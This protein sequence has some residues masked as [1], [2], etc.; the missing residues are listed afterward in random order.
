MTKCPVCSTQTSNKI[1]NT[2]YWDCGYCGCW[3]Q[4]PLPSKTYEADH[5]KGPN[6]EFTGHLMPDN[7]KEC[8]RGLATFIFTVP[9]G[10]KS[11]PGKMLDIGAKYPYLSYCFKEL[12]CEAYAMDNIEIVPEYSKELDVPMLM[13][14]F[15]KI[16]EEQIKEW[17]KTEKFDLITMI[18]TFEHMEHPLEALKKMRKLLSDDGSLFLRLPQHDVSGYERDLTTGHYTIHPFF[19]SLSSLLELLVQARN[20]FTVIWQSP[21]EGAGQRDLILKPL[22]KK[23][24]IW[25]G[26]I[27]KNEERDLPLCLKTIEAVVDGIVIMDTGSTDNTE[28]NAKA[29]WHKPM[30]YETY[31]GASKQDDKGDWKLWDFGKARNQ[32]VER[33]EAMPE[34]DYLIWFDAD[35]TLLTA[36]NLRKAFYMGNWD[37]FGMQIENGGMKWV[38]HR[39]WKTKKGIHFAGKI[40]EYGVI[41]NCSTFILE[42]TIIHHDAA[43][44]IGEDSN[45]RNLRILLSELEETPNDL[46]TLFYTANTYKD[47]GKFKEAIPYYKSRIEVGVGYFD[48]WI[49]AYLYKARCE[50]AAD[51]L[52][53]AETTLL[54]ACSKAMNWSEL[55]MELAYMAYDTGKSELCISYCLQ[56]AFRVNAPS[57]LWKEP[58]KASDQPRRMMSFA[59]NALGR[60]EEALYWALE[61][62]KHIGT[63]DIS[64][65]ERV[66]YL[67]SLVGEKQSIA[68]KPKKIALHRPGAIGDII[69]T[70]NLI[71]QLKEKYPN[72]EIDYFCDAGIGKS[73]EDFFISAGISKWYDF[74][75]LSIFEHEYEHVFNMI[76]YPIPPKGNYPEEPMNQHLLHSFAE[77]AGLDKQ[78][79]L[80]Q[81]SISEKPSRVIGNE[82][83][84]IHSTAGWSVFKNW[85]V[86]NWE[87]VIKAFPDIRF[88][89]IGAYADYKL[90]GADHS[91]MGR[92]L[93]YSI[94]LIANAK[95][96]VGIDSFSNHL[97]HIKWA[98][99]QTP[100][101]ILWGS[102]QASAA[103]YPENTNISLGL[104]CQPC[105][106]ENPAISRQPRGMCPNPPEQTYENPKHECMHKITVPQVI[107]AIK[108]KLLN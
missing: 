51:L 33:I 75:N 1:I 81:L 46:R 40:H 10:M 29:V 9:D 83:I 100:A 11:K 66:K 16:T 67:E 20:L 6:G 77:E 21:M 85:P 57:Q 80:P 63:E 4:N 36:N 37:V 59:Y 98:D 19:H 105:F 56:A 84:T 23:P 61:A 3:F 60:N 32:F 94:S 90:K 25:A 30:I 82:Y 64:W 58:N 41:N 49:F 5:E 86:E 31:T 38:H 70:L 99:K 12:G 8:N 17:T 78:S 7:E 22:K 13:A 45:A 69:M 28:K 26:M 55:W 44:G 53:D 102:T 89:Q 18:H 62:K 96:Q 107:E 103:G 50:R 47:A 2:P 97:T 73:L 65:D 101:V 14:D 76:G 92:E 87:A 68:T 43:P 35:D 42:D 88:V 104:S 48:E 71:P 24:T 95:L 39:A 106:R 91:Y 15:E 74:N 27:V 93:H 54:E 34:V 52:Q 108:L 79:Y 72:Y